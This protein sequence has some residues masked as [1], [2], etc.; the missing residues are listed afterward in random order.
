MFCIYVEVELLHESLDARHSLAAP[1]LDAHHVDERVAANFPLSARLVEAA[2][3]GHEPG[4]APGHKRAC[5]VSQCR[6]I[7]ADTDWAAKHAPQSPQKAVPSNM[8]VNH[9]P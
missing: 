5:R 9:S 8:S 1:A 2:G 6:T 7:P 4:L 3:R